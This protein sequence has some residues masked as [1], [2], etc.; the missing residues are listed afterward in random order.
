MTINILVATPQTSFGELLRLCL[1][2]SSKYRVR[3][4]QN[5]HE[6]LAASGRINFD[7]AIL[8]AALTDQP[9]PT[10][11]HSLTEPNPGL[12][13]VVIPPEND[14]SRLSLNGLHPDA[15]LNLPFYA[16]DFFDLVGKLIASSNASDL[17]STE[18]VEAFHTPSFQKNTS[19]LTASLANQLVQTTAQAALVICRRELLASTGRLDLKQ[20]QEMADILNHCW[21]DHDPSDLSRYVRLTGG[22]GEFKI[23]TTCLAEDTLM[24]LVYDPAAPLTRMRSQAVKAAQALRALP[25]EA[26]SAAAPVAQAEIE[27]PSPSP[28]FSVVEEPSIP[29]TSAPPISVDAG[30]DELADLLLTT[31]PSGQEDADLLLALENDTRPLPSQPPAAVTLAEY[32]PATTAQELNEPEDEFTEGSGEEGEMPEVSLSDLLAAVPP[33]DPAERQWAPGIEWI[34]GDDENEPSGDFLFPWEKADQVQAAK[35]ASLEEIQVAPVSA[36]LTTARTV[37]TTQPASILPIEAVMPVPVLPLHIPDPVPSEGATEKIIRMASKPMSEQVTAPMIVQP[38]SLTQQIAPTANPISSQPMV[39]NPEIWNK[40][41]ELENLSAEFAS[42]SY[43][44]VMLPRLPDIQITGSLARKLAEWLP[45]ICLA[46]GWRLV[47]QAIRPDTFQWTIQVSATVSPG[48]VVRVVRL[49]T[50]RYIFEQFKRFTDVI[51]SGD[52]WAPGYLIIS[53]SQPPDPRLV[54]E[55]IHQTRKRQ[56]VTR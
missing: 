50:S 5:G 34:N 23:Y 46:Y 17:A 26:R 36:P 53:G 54:G 38:A 41:E 35:P 32:E 14:P 2:E 30:N 28:S 52:F 6:A 16:P 8:D 44:C 13:L 11:I 4:V 10:L 45:N 47:D 24:A 55:Y 1:E 15:Y 39:V 3:L 20:L 33:P 31:A 7:L 19:Q 21:D 56:G 51:P 37:E 12:R 9:F 42:L 25:D 22:G 43:T 27:Q 18:P 49:Q 48:S 40:N 29:G